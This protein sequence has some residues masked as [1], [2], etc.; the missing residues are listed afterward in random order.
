MDYIWI[1][2]IYLSII[3]ATHFHYFNFY[4]FINDN[5]I[6]AGMG[7]YQTLKIPSMVNRER[8]WD[9]E[10]CMCFL[11]KCLT[12]LKQNVKTGETYILERKPSSDKLTLTETHEVG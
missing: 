6:L 8:M 2:E 3:K 12:F 5:G 4:S 11:D 10:V 1:T 9:S 7:Q